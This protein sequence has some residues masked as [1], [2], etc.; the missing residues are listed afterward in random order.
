MEKTL[1]F[2][3]DEEKE[4]FIESMMKM[5]TSLR[6][7][8][9]ISQEELSNFIGVSRQ[10]YGCIE[11]RLK[12]MTWGTYLSLVMFFDVNVNTHQL[13]RESDA[14]PHKIYRL[15]ECNPENNS[16]IIS[17]HTFGDEVVN[18]FDSLDEQAMSTLKTVLTIEYS[19]CNNISGAEVIRFFEGLDFSVKHPEENTKKA[20]KAL[21]N[22]K[23]NRKNVK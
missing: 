10:T 6:A 12:K 13:F 1:V 21:K 11:R 9:G 4:N 14:F 5:L 23:R 17:N 22:I 15:F 20:A 18:V 2:L 8:A 19:R 3:T 16:G 7:K